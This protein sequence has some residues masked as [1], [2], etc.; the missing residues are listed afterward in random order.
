MTIIKNIINKIMTIHISSI[1][2]LKLKVKVIIDIINF[3]SS[4]K[5]WVFNC[6]EWHTQSKVAHILFIDHSRNEM[7]V[8][9]GDGLSPNP[10]LNIIHQGCVGIRIHLVRGGFYKD[11]YMFIVW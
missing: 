11:N 4:I 10:Q 1:S 7:H 3:N 9:H 6:R 5:G 2:R 8:Y